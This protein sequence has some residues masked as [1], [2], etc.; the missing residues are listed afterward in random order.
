MESKTE[1]DKLAEKGSV[2]LY[3]HQLPATS[4]V[5][6]T[7]RAGNT[8]YR[9]H[10]STQAQHNAGT[11]HNFQYIPSAQHE[12]H[13]LSRTSS[14]ANTRSNANNR[15]PLLSTPPGLAACQNQINDRDIKVFVQATGEVCERLSSGLPN[16][17]VFVAN[18]N[19]LL[20]R[21]GYSTISIPDTMI[22]LSNQIYINN[23]SNG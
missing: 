4:K 3:Q 6:N 9:G 8:N 22:K 14:W 15:P 18:F 10:P 5:S 21:Q 7:S 17:E 20:S 16:P 19:E 23:P 11:R 2:H 1:K 13:A 12:G